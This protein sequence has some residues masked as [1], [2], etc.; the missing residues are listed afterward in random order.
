ME[1]NPKLS[2]T[3]REFDMSN[4]PSEYIGLE[5]PSTDI[6]ESARELF[7]L[8]TTPVT[9]NHQQPSGQ[10]S[11]SG[12]SDGPLFPLYTSIPPYYGAVYGY[13]VPI[14]SSS[15]GPLVDLSRPSP[16][17]S[18]YFPP[19]YVQYV[20]NDMTGI[21]Y[22]PPTVG[23]QMI[24]EMGYNAPILNEGKGMEVEDS[25][26]YNGEKCVEDF[27]SAKSKRV[28][29]IKTPSTPTSHYASGNGY[30]P[31]RRR[32]NDYQESTS[33]PQV[34]LTDTGNQE[35]DMEAILQEFVR[36]SRNTNPE[37][38]CETSQGESTVTADGLSDHQKDQM[39]QITGIYDLETLLQSGMD[40]FSTSNTPGE[41]ET[42]DCAQTFIN[43]STRTS[44]LPDIHFLHE[45]GNHHNAAIHEFPCEE[46]PDVMMS[47]ESPLGAEKITVE[48]YRG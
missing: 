7:G 18:Q 20:H 9:K 41:E 13:P 35:V 33:I 32:L 44:T 16:F 1:L 31:K 47:S 46:N 10:C 25:V 28:H 23:N 11:P 37:S 4:T 36:E 21:I 27:G 26:N 39:V 45:A 43:D 19:Q 12:S 2:P 14:A 42:I 5:A 6:D 29:K 40:S 48:I 30:V 38:K 8:D 15:P 17:L 34:H 22:G 24:F 3:E